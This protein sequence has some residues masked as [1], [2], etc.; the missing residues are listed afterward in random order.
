MPIWFEWMDNLPVTGTV[1]VV[2][3]GGTSEEEDGRVGEVVVD[4]GSM[5]VGGGVGDVV[6]HSADVEGD[7][8]VE[9]SG[10]ERVKIIYQSHQ[11]ALMSDG[12][13]KL[14]GNL[15]QVMYEVVL[16]TVHGDGNDSAMGKA[17]IRFAKQ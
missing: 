5:R 13:W 7:A 9:S 2:E 15:L 10:P 11:S 8:G 16:A 1:D 17:S 3:E 6:E 12:V 14:P 4:K